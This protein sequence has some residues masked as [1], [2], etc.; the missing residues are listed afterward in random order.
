[1]FLGAPNDDGN[2]LDLTLYT[3]LYTFKFIYCFQF[4]AN[5]LHCLSKLNRVF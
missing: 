1:M 5:I 3:K 4:L 2:D